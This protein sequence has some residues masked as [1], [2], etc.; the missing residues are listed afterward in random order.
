MMNNPWNPILSAPDKETVEVIDRMDGTP[1]LA[2]KDAQGN[3]RNRHSGSIAGC[4]PL[5]WR[6]VRVNKLS[7]DS[8]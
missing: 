1:F 6:P 8:Q 7:G 4:K 3:W 5:Y 2:F